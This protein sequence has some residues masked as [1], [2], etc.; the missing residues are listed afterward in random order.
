MSCICTFPSKGTEPNQRNNNAVVIGSHDRGFWRL[1]KLF[2]L[3]L[4]SYSVRSP[5]G[6]YRLCARIHGRG[7]LSNRTHTLAM[8]LHSAVIGLIPSQNCH[9]NRRYVH[10]QSMF[11]SDNLTVASASRPGG[12]LRGFHVLGDS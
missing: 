3:Q 4:C 12:I 8:R 7:V 1:V 6:S 10:S 11:E 9:V 2:I 5:A